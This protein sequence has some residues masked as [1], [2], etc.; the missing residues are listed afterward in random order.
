MVICSTSTT[1][2]TICIT[3]RWRKIA[4]AV[5]SAILTKH[6]SRRKTASTWSTPAA[7]RSQGMTAMDPTPSSAPHRTVSRRPSSIIPPLWAAVIKTCRGRLYPQHPQL[8]RQ[9]LA[10]ISARQRSLQKAQ[11]DLY[12]NVKNGQHLS[13]I[14]NGH[15][16]FY[17]L[18]DLLH[19]PGLD[20]HDNKRDYI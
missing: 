1:V 13:L 14:D 7:S 4:S 16:P 19:H 18:M 20:D 15:C 12:K 11:C 6:W 9:I 3:K 2:W 5:F 8:Q 10:C 17:L